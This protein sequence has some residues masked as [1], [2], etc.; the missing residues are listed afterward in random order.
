MDRREKKRAQAIWAE[1][2]A[3]ST[4]MKRLQPEGKLTIKK[5]AIVAG[6]E[7]REDVAAQC[8]CYSPALRGC[9]TTKD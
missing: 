9:P 7:F 3:L 1:G 4:M 2:E 6:G 5:C 8:G